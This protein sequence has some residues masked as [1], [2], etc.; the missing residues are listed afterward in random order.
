M[1]G[2]TT[3]EISHDMHDARTYQLCPIA[4]SAY[5]PKVVICGSNKR[6][7]KMLVPI[8][9]SIDLRSDLREPE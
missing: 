7:E 6:S 5:S 8:V 4:A 3:T 2:A 9:L 1:E